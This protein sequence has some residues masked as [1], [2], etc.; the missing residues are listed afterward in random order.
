ML[1]QL[2]ARLRE[3]I[4]TNDEETKE[5]LPLAAAVLYLEVAWADHD[6]ADAEIDKIR[7]R[8]AQQFKLPADQIEKIIDE[9]RAQHDASV[10][11]Y[12]FTRTL[13]DG[14]DEPTKFELLVSLWELALIDDDLDAFEEHTIR[15]IAELLYLSHDRFIEAKIKARRS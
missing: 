1:S 2:L 9:S 6:I 4:A 10:G 15:K 12:R 3:P 14:W 5:L 7:S 13:N 11:I 8:L